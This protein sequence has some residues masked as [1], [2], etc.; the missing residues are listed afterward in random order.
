VSL[1]LEKY[2]IVGF[3][4]DGCIA[5][6]DKEATLTTIYEKMRNVLDW[7]LGPLDTPISSW[8]QTGLV[9]DVAEGLLVKLNYKRKVVRAFRGFSEEPLGSPAVA[10]VQ[11]RV[12]KWYAKDEDLPKL[13]AT[14]SYSN[15]SETGLKMYLDSLELPKGD[16][17]FT[18]R[19]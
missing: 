19:M 14:G 5:E 9:L 3:D 6:Y 10:S 2:D 11:G 17:K 18:V 12:D 1:N 4:L 7:D 13:T 16:A 8:V 15:W